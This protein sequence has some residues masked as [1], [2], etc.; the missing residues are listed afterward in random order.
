MKTLPFQ[1]RCI[2]CEAGAGGKGR[3]AYL[4][5]EEIQTQWSQGWSVT[6]LQMLV[7][8]APERPRAGPY[9]SAF[10]HLLPDLIKSVV[11]RRVCL[12]HRMAKD[13]EG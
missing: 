8:K 11:V 9:G 7:R 12:L 4:S 1:L 6:V 13:I 3:L 5:A 2:L 10:G